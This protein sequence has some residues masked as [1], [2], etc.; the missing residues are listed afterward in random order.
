MPENGNC[1]VAG[2]IAHWKF[3]VLEGEQTP[4]ASGNN[5]VGKVRYIFNKKYIPNLLFGQ[6]KQST[7]VENGALLLDGKQWISGGNNKCYNID[8]FT[9][10]LWVW[11]DNRE[12]HMPTIM[13]KSSWKGYDGWWLCV[14]PDGSVD[15]GIAWGNGFSHVK[16]GYRLPL[17]EW[18]YISCTV[19]NFTNEVQFFIDGLPYGRKHSDVH[20]W[21][22]NWNHDL[23]IGEYDGS[24]YWPWPG[25]LDEVSFYSTILPK[26]K[27]YELYFRAKNSIPANDSV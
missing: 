10:S 18:H 1:E 12:I 19:D 17:K 26:D 4:D 5:N 8:K 13:A 16:S 9:I 14:T 11:Q 2:L 6:P 7:G 24:G 15:L 20:S 22:V 25:K 3:D 27:I 21:R 23:F